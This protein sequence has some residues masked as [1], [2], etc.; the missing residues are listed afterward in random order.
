M[1][2][3]RRSWLRWAGM[4][5][6]A[7]VAAP[8]LAQVAETGEAAPEALKSTRRRLQGGL[9]GVDGNTTRVISR[10]D[11][12]TLAQVNATIMAASYNHWTFGDGHTIT[13]N[14]DTGDLT[15][16]DAT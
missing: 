9:F 11:A 3:T 6:G 10:R 2:V 5:L 16:T 14:R 15:F 13:Q 12:S 1:D 4:G 8:A 7:A